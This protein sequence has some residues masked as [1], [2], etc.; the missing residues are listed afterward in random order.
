MT[1]HPDQPTAWR[2]DALYQLAAKQ[3]CRGGHW[4][5]WGRRLFEEELPALEG[6][7]RA[8]GLAQDIVAAALSLD[9]AAQ[10]LEQIQQM[11]QKALQ[12]SEDQLLRR[13][14]AHGGGFA[15][16]LAQAWLQA[17]DA[18]RERLRDGFGHLLDRYRQAPEVA[19]A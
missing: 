13:M 10:L 5:E 7:L 15:Q 2:L 1:E 11:C 18:N 3:A 14:A 17:D 6:R 8:A 12:P 4:G 19:H 16:A 9:H